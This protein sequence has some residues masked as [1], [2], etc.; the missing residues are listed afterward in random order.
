MVRFSNNGLRVP[1]CQQES[2][3]VKQCVLIFEYCCGSQ[4]CAPDVCQDMTARL[5][6]SKVTAEGLRAA[7]ASFT[8]GPIKRHAAAG[9]NF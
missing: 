5:D 2:V 7:R 4:S 3:E 8:V 9:L 6:F 1:L